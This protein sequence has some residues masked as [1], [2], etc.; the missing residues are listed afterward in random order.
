MSLGS[1]LTSL[2]TYNMLLYRRALH[3]EFFAIEGRRRLT[4][5]DCEFEAWIFRGGHSLRMLRDG[6]CMCE[7]VTDQLDHLPEKGLAATLPCAGERDHEEKVVEGITFMTSM[8]TETL[9]DHLYVGTVRELLELPA[10]GLDRRPWQGE[11]LDRR[12]AAVP[13]R[14]AHAGLPPAERLRTGPAD[15]VDV[16]VRQRHDGLSVSRPRRIDPRDGRPVA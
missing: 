4:L 9:S 8:Q 14:G 11:S 7:L 16:P 10:G 3:P 5:G 12:S 6:D 2:Q 15:A 13:R 1:K